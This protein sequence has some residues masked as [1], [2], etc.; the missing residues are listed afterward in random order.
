MIWIVILVFTFII[1]DMYD[2]I[3][4]IETGAIYCIT[5][6]Q[7]EYFI[8]E[9]E[10]GYPRLTMTHEYPVFTWLEAKSIADRHGL[11]VVSVFEINC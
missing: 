2:R 9:T 10:Q 8:G 3:K 11:Y 4:R 1:A 6:K 7:G 5:N